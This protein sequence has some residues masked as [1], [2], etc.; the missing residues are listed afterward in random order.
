M[1]QLLLQIDNLISEQNSLKALLEKSIEEL[2]KMKYEITNTEE[3]F[4]VV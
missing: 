4:K 2:K 1:N 3:L